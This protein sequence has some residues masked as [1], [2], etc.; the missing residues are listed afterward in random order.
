[1]FFRRFTCSAARWHWLC[2]CLK[3]MITSEKRLL[4]FNSTIV[5]YT[6]THKHA[7]WIHQATG[8]TNKCMDFS[9]KRPSPFLFGRCSCLFVS[10][11]EALSSCLH[12]LQADESQWYTWGPYSCL[13]PPRH[14]LG[15]LWRGMSP[16]MAWTRLWKHVNNPQ[17]VGAS[18]CRR[19]RPTKR[20]ALKTT[21]PFLHSSKE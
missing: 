13:Q 19:D 7:L 18:Q 1:M 21:G 15:P 9:P 4:G 12:W 16:F 20:A 2:F 5:Y 11:D 3:W 10:F 14:T 8:Q 6:H 17:A